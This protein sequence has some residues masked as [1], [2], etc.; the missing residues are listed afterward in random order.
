VLADYPQVIRYDA[1]RA[2]CDERWC[3]GM[4]DGKVLY[5][6]DDHLS[7]EGSHF[8]AEHFMREVWH[9]E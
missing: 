7:L 5:R 8:Q 9:R 4:K 2:F 6:D 3:W 1:W